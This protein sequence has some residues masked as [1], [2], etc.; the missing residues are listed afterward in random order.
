MPVSLC[1]PCLLVHLFPF[2]ISSVEVYPL[3]TP[4]SVSLFVDCQYQM[5]LFIQDPFLFPVPPDELSHSEVTHT[6]T[7]AV[8]TDVMLNLI[9]QQCILFPF[10]S[11]SDHIIQGC[12]YP[13]PRM[14]KEKKSE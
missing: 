9:S 6:H 4:L 1:F 5:S 11:L 2:S 13:N 8:H 14:T 12:E 10:L 7:E 3:A